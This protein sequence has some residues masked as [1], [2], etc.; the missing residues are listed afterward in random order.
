MKP[1]GLKAVEKAKADGR[2][3]RHTI[4]QAK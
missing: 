4:P 1:T 3:E 2:W